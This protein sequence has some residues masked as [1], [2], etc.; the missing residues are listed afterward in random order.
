MTGP[1]SPVRIA[2]VGGVGRSGTTV[3]D[4]MLGGSPGAVSVGEIVHL[5][6]RG[7]L[8]DETCGCGEA[9]HGCEFW[10]A[11]GHT[12]YGG[13]SVGLAR[14][15]LAL[16]AR[17]D[18]TRFVPAL[19]RPGLSRD[20]DAAATELL[21]VLV[22]LYQAIRQVSGATVV[23]DSNKHASYAYL[24]RRTGDLETGIVHVVRA[25]E[26]VAYSWQRAVARPETSDGRDMPTYSA[27]RVAGRWVA[28][29]LLLDR[30]RASGDGLLVRYED[31]V[32]E[33][34]TEVRR[35]VEAL[36]MPDADL[37]HV[38]D[39]WA[40]LAPAH[41]VAGN[42]MRF[43]T[44]RL[45]LR[46]DDAWVTGLSGRDRALVRT[47]VRPV[48]HRYGYPLTAVRQARDA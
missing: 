19:A 12:A 35:I 2:Y 10:R 25:V 24:L 31:L 17:C 42:P 3:L 39:G 5:W 45:Q 23:V 26:G 38:G 14:R 48:R 34:S 37:G 46:P 8:D 41:T 47:L 11:V 32:A 21:G 16:K 30:L 36:G 43:R 15:V 18:R 33:P 44:G 9:F 13:W 1:T 4:R 6:Y 7:V 28:Q 27:G 20:V 29:N 22:P 40:D